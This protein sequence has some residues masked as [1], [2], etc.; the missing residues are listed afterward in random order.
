MERRDPRI[1]VL[2]YAVA[3]W[4]VVVGAWRMVG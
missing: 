4:T 1:F 3:A 2:L